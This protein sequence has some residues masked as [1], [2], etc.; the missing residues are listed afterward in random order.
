MSNR[1]TL[2]R[3]GSISGVQP[4]A[5]SFGLGLAVDD[6][7]IEPDLVAAPARGIPR[8]SRPTRQA[9]VAISRARV[10]PRLRILSR[11]IESASI[12]AADRRLAEPAGRRHALAEPDDARERVDDAEAL[13]NR[14]R[15]QQTAI[16]GA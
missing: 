5:A 12:G 16:V 15:D 8:R 3:A 9:S 11:Q 13:A 6:L 7:E 4:I 10:A 1:M 2:S 14:A